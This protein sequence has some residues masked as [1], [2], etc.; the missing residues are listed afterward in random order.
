VKYE[1]ALHKSAAYC[2]SSEHCIYELKEKLDKWEVEPSDQLRIITYLKKEKY[3]DEGRYAVAFV[4][5]KF[6]YNKWG[7][8]KI[9][10]A[11]SV[12]KISPETIAD[13][14]QT[15]DIMEYN[16]LIIKLI[17]DKL[18]NIKYNNQYDK[19]AKLLRYITSKG[20]ETEAAIQLIKMQE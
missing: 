18:K 3:I 8:M 19:Q 17:K 4:K 2:S 1:Q 16:E 14:L 6:R 12:K 7:K 13:A 5:D 11:L 10:M 9:A 15:I 20:F